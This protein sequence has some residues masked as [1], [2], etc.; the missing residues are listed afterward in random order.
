[1]RL[2]DIERHRLRQPAAAQRQKQ[3][4]AVID[5]MLS[6]N[7][8]RPEAWLARYVYRKSIKAAGEPV[9]PDADA[10]LDKA[11]EIGKKHPEPGPGRRAALCGP[12]RQQPEGACSA[13][14]FFEQA[15]RVRPTDF[16]GWLRLGEL[17]ESDGTDAARAQAVDIWTKGLESVGHCEIDL[18]MPLSAALIQL[19]RFADAEEKLRPLDSAVKRLSEPGR[20]LVELG[21][22]RLRAGAAAAKGNPVQAATMLRDELHATRD[23]FG[24]HRLSHS[25]CRR[26]DAAG[27]LL[28]RPAF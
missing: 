18:V 20:S 14:Q 15:T 19:K 24:Q 27:R 8:D 13:Q 26:L 22:T 10:D 7:A 6:R 9:S 23:G 12:T 28:F 25:V 3:A 11:I 21:A 4:D 5:A 16:R 17:A 2:A 1:M